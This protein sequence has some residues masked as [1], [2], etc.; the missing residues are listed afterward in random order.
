MHYKVKTGMLAWILHRAS[1][2]AL[3][4]Y[5]PL[6]IYATSSLHDPEKFNLVMRFLNQPIFKLAEIGLLAAVIYHSL[7]GVRI[8]IIDWFGGTRNH[9]KVFWVLAIIGIILFIAG[10]AT[11]VRHGLTELR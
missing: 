11:F 9:V 8:L 7:N 6:H 5:L 2:I 4:F 1:G 3:A 10:S